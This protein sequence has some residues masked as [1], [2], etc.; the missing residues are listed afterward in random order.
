[1]GVSKRLVEFLPSPAVLKEETHYS[2]HCDHPQ[3]IG[4]V[5]TFYGNFAV[6]VRAYVYIRML[7][8]EGL[9][10][11]SRGAI[12]NANYLLSQLKS[13]Y[14][15]PFPRTPMHEF[16]LSGNRQKEKGVK[17]MDIAKRLL[18]FRVHAPTVYFPLIVPEALMIEPTE[19]ESKASIDEFAQILIQ[20]AEEA[21]REPEV[22]LNAPY[23][24]PV[25]RLDEAR[26]ARD[27]NV[28]YK[29]D[30]K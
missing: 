19:T 14:D 23:S 25:S 8:A 1:V 10:H 24:T 9:R 26:A 20:I 27:L 5:S 29:F 22:V 3:S 17:T 4:K 11:V 28:C 12:I 16:V 15:L 18:D 2:F 13:H 7:G 30:E 21:E 6:F